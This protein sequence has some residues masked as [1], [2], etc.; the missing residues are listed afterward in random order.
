[1]G[2]YYFTALVQL[3]GRRDQASARTSAQRPILSEPARQMIDVEV[4]TRRRARGVR[5]GPI[6]T[7]VTSFDVQAFATA[8]SRCTEPRPHSRCPTRNVRRR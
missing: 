7:L 4:P 5:V 1:M 2:P 6:A 3:L 8:T